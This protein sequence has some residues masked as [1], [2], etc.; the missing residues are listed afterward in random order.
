MAPKGESIYCIG[1]W[2]P[3]KKSYAG[4]SER[5][6][7]LKRI[8]QEI[9][10][11]DGISHYT[12]DDIEIPYTKVLSFYNPDGRSSHFD[13]LIH[14]NLVNK[15]GASSQIYTE[16]FELPSAWKNPRDIFIDA[17]E[18]TAANKWAKFDPARPF[19][20]GPRKGSQDEAIKAVMKAK[21]HG[22][23]KLLLGCKC[24]FGKTFTAL[25]IFYV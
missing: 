22:V 17:I 10:S 7:A 5:E 20:Y 13:K 4:L 6:G 23:K 19:S 18:K 9:K 25:Y 2:D 14:R 3:S 11:K 8:A 15:F 24:R 16:F 21:K 1:E 12:L